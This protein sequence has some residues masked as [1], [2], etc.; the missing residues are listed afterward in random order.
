M[1][2]NNDDLHLDVL[3]LQLRCDALETLCLALVNTATNKDDVLARFQAHRLSLESKFLNST[4]FE[5][6][7]VQETLRAHAT[8]AGLLP[9][10]S[11]QS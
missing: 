9:P 1:A 6:V 4:E 8:I 11:S 7:V 2:E 10:A 5:E 3:R